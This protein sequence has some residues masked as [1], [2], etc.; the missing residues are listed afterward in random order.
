MIKNISTYI[1]NANTQKTFK[2]MKLLVMFL[3]V[4][5]S[6]GYAGNSYSQTTTLNL[7]M[8]NKTVREVFNEIE[9]NSEYIF[10]Y[11]RE[12]LDPNRAVSIT[13]V[14]ETISKV[15]DKL[16]EGT[17]NIYKVSDRQVYISKA[18]KQTV[19]ASPEQQQKRTIRGNVVDENGEPIIGANIIER[20]TS[21]GTVTDFDGNF[22]LP[23]GENAILQISYLG[24]IDE[25]V[26]T[27]GKTSFSIILKEDSKSLDEVVVTALG[28]KKEAKSLSYNVQQ[29]S[30]NDINKVPDA[31]F[32]NSLS[33]K[34]AG[35][36]I[37]SASSGIGGASRVVMRGAKSIS[38][39]NNALY[40]V[41]GVPLFNVERGEVSDRFSGAGQSGDI[42]A[43]INPDDIE[44]ISVLSGASAAALYGSAAANG[45][46]M[47]TTKRGQEG[48]TSI[49]LSNST[50]FSNALVLP[51]FQNTYGTSSVGDFYSW[52]DKL[53]T[54]SS[55]SPKDFFQTGYSVNN[56][57]N[58]STGT[59]KNQ[60]YVSLGN[61]IAEGIIRNNDYN[62]INFT[63]R[64]TTKFLNDK[65][66]LD[67]QYSLSRINEQN[68][69]AQGLYHN[70]IVPVYLFP[71]GDD[72]EKVKAF[73]RFNA[74][75]NFPTQ[76]WPYDDGLGLQNP[77]W[78]TDR[79][80]FDNQK[81]RHM[82]T[83]SL[84]YEFTKGINLSGRFRL[85]QGS[86]QAERKFNAST[87]NLFASETGFY[88]LNEMKSRQ[89]YG[90]ALLNID[91]YFWED[92]LNLIANIGASVDDIHYDQNMYGGKLAKVPNL[93]T[94][95]NVAKS[96]AE[97][98]QT[99][100]IKQKQSVFASAQFGYKSMA[101]LDV[102]ARND[103]P[104]TL[105]NT[106]TKSFFYPSIGL[107]GIITDIFGISTWTMPYMKLRASYSRVGNEPAY[108]IA[109]PTYLVADG[110]PGTMTRMH[111]PNLKPEDTKAWEVGANIGLFGS[112]MT[113]DATL[114]K[115]ETFNQIFDVPLAYSSGYT[116][117][118]LNA[119]QI[120]NKGI[121]LTAKYKEKLGKFTWDTY[122]TYSLNRNKIVKL[123]EDGA[124]NPVTG[125]QIT[126]PSFDM[127]GTGNYRISLREGG[128]MSDIYVSSIRTDEH[129]AI[130]V[131]PVSNGVIAEANK[132]IYAGSAAPKYNLGWGNNF[133]WNGINLGFQISA[134]VGGVGVSNTQAL[135]DYYGVSK[136]SAN[137]RDEGGALV[138]GYRIPAKAY[139][140][141]I[142]APNGGAASMYVYSATNIRL[143]ELTI[144]YDVPINK[145]TDYIKSMNVSFIGNN[146][147]FLYKKAPYDPEVT[148]STGTYF[149]GIDYFM[150]P[151]LRNLGF[152]VKLQ[153]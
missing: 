6:I 29:V 121:E 101:Y 124:K 97:P 141:T 48:K 55:Y 36:T 137:A 8:N 93:F 67:L 82:S 73:E 71:A 103:W 108:Q 9:K 17:D 15:L 3:I 49:N 138:N 75:R 116:S 61:M 57:M 117:I 150:Q 132:F 120:D 39:N 63:F 50:T 83:A 46:V 91:R 135:L 40:V 23:V 28:I 113:I 59:D 32:I 79:E 147:L 44:S 14:N 94:Y 72:F 64:N 13:V 51:E 110:I 2:I 37:N 16:F 27:K 90:E 80:K 19:I 74:S 1:K 125:D 7:K 107:S 52:G 81:T 24:Y 111:N 88:S 84:N 22:Q 34:V 10:L 96:T 62:R 25:V 5:I 38:G 68:M 41:D 70:P 95:S 12:T 130:F 98:S 105:A 11:N 145:W 136:A 31:N 123:I 21:N 18:E 54:P 43:S 87:N 112:K 153:F 127:A 151:S 128:T 102:T 26:N 99:G 20:G 139:Y 45:V 143:S 118:Y 77:Y 30:A 133:G 115:S 152:S 85:D 126:L 69:V 106:K 146:L 119:G 4:G 142:G 89:M 42:L 122:L 47:V 140:E 35:V 60:T 53:S 92:K 131:D 86:E 100:Y 144:G 76:Y 56:S 149:Q 58:L 33:G 109:I 66:T 148:A 104:S 134:R 129:G 78:V 114:Y 65:L